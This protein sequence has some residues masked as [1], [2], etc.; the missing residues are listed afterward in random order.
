[1][2]FGHRQG[3]RDAMGAQCRNVGEWVMD[4]ILK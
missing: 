4:K 2:D 1:M 3:A